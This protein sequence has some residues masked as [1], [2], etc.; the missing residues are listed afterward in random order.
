MT[1]TTIL[2]P[3]ERSRNLPNRERF[4]ATVQLLQVGN[5]P[6]PYWS[7]QGELRDLRRR[8]DNAIV[9]SGCMHDEVLRYFPK[10]AP[11]VA[12][13]LSDSEG[14]PS[15]AVANARHWLGLTRF[16][17]WERTYGKPEPLPAL[18]VLAR[19]LRITEADALA[20]SQR[21]RAD[22]PDYDDDAFV[23]E[24]NAM[25]ARW[26]SEHDAAVALLSELLEA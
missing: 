2:G 23:G 14:A 22:D 15:H 10:L 25:R 5:N 7:V 19:H 8:G 1:T 24:V 20:M 18:D 4:T 9:A 13:H 16:K 26:Q 21:Y 6:L 12:L 11:F 3:L 17:T